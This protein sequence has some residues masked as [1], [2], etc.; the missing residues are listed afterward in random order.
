MNPGKLF[1]WRADAKG[2]E[3]RSDT[4]RGQASICFFSQA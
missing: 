2:I 4:R 3:K 1:P